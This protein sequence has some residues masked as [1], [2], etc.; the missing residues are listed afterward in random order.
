L[1]IGEI[2]LRLGVKGENLEKLGKFKTDAHG[3]AGAAGSLASA[4]GK[5]DQKLKEAGD[6]IRE[7]LG[8]LTTIRLQMLAT[9]GAMTLLTEKASKVAFELSKFTNLTGLSA[10]KLQEWQQ[11]AAASNVSAE[12]MQT[13]I[14]G[15]R[16][17]SVDIS[18]GKGNLAPW[19][20]L[21]ID[22]RQ[23]PFVILDQLQTKLKAFPAAMGTKLA[24]D[25]GLGGNMINFLKEAKNLQAVDKS[26]LLSD[27]EIARLKEFNILFNRIWDNAKRTMQQFGIIAQPIAEFVLKAFDRMSRAM[28]DGVRVVQWLGDRFKSLG[29]ILGAIAVAVAAY[30]FPVTA[31]LIATALVLEDIASYARGDDSIIGRLIE[32]YKDFHAV[33]LD[34]TLALAAIADIVTGGAYTDQISAWVTGK[35]ERYQ[36]GEQQKNGPGFSISPGSPL[37]SA[38]QSPLNQTNNVNITVSGAGSPEEVATRLDKK[39]RDVKDSSARTMFQLPLGETP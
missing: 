33:L 39:I 4:A 9:V 5:I 30:F 18:L 26:L 13:S 32:R 38:I 37:G 10:Q 31:A 35:E 22:P 24:G 21:G 14:E 7:F 29:P 11:A 12:E 8:P 17:A 23:D 19:A 1:N 36:Q 28:M 27:K 3:A 34:V 25:L 20:M 15:L 6:R 2:F 16:Q